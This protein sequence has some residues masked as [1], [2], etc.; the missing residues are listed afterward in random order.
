M[1]HLAN[2]P[3]RRAEHNTKGERFGKL[4][5]SRHKVPLNPPMSSIRRVVHFLPNSFPGQP[6]HIGNLLQRAIFL[7]ID[8][9]TVFSGL[10]WNFR[11]DIIGIIKGSQPAFKQRGGYSQSPGS[12]SCGTVFNSV[13]TARNEFFPAVLL[14][15]MS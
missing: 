1:Q 10:L 13:N 8:R 3:A 11:T 9:V 12:N 7:A 2:F 4:N 14:R 15:M 6:F 5:L